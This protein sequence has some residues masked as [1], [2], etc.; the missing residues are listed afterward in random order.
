MADSAADMDI[1]ENSTLSGLT[2]RMTILRN[3]VLRH[4]KIH[5]STISNSSMYQCTVHT[6]TISEECSLERC[7]VLNS[8]INGCTAVG[9]EIHESAFTKVKMNRCKITTSPLAL[10]RFAP[11]IR[12]IILQYCTPWNVWKPKIPEILVA[13]RGDE[14]LY[15]EALRAFYKQN[16][17]RLEFSN[18]SRTELMSKKAIENINKL[19]ISYVG[20]FVQFDVVYQ[21]SC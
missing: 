3:C 15:H 10:C 17:F 4:V 5:A 9:S 12:A 14:K 21:S 7:I 13:L 19:C 2:I 6:S 16:W 1:I 18:F 11:E 8:T 20:L